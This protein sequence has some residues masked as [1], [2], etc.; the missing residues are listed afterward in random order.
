M[1]GNAKGKLYCGR[2]ADELVEDGAYRLRAL[3]A[4]E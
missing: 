4:D 2:D 3:L 1:Y